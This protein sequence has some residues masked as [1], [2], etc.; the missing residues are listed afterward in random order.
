MELI[1]Q[2]RIDAGAGLVAAPEV[3]AKRFDDV[4][5][6]DA[7]VRAAFLDHL[8]NAVQHAADAAELRVF[9]TARTTRAVEVTKQLVGAVDEMDD[10]RDVNIAAIMSATN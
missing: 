5:G 2:N 4:V 6:G 3:V 8:Q 7:N 1:P 9:A 10:H